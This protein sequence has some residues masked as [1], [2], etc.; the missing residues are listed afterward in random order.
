[1]HKLIILAA[2]VLLFGEAMY[3]AQ[4]KSSEKINRFCRRERNCDYDTGLKCINN[5][6]RCPPEK[7]WSRPQKICALGF[8]KTCELIM[9]SSH[10]KHS[11]HS[12]QSAEDE[13]ECN[14]S[15][16]LFCDTVLN[17]CSCKS[18]TTWSMTDEKC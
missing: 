18:N 9:D 13:D 11:A 15:L 8:N 5:T 16:G 10:E 4:S 7:M 1:M 3:L 2:I 17:L 6:C 14:L 12:V